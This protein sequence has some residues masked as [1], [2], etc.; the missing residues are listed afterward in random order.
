MFG[1]NEP[2]PKNSQGL[3]GLV[4]QTS[5]MLDMYGNPILIQNLPTSRFL[6]LQYLSGK[7]RIYIGKERITLRGPGS[8]NL[9]LHTDENMMTV[10]FRKYK[11]Q[12]TK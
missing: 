2:K 9:P 4:S 6:L 10:S 1:L 8:A 3:V 11:R 12:K 5:G 7:E